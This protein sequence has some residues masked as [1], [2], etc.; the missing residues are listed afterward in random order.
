MRVMESDERI[1]EEVGELVLE[2]VNKERVK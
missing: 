2:R 1:S